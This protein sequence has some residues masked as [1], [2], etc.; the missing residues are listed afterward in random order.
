M[1]ASVDASGV[2]GTPR[3]LFDTRNWLDYDVA[4][5]G[6]FIAVVSQKVAGQEPLA[7]ILNWRG[8]GGREQ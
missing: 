3:V 4:R 7:V 8:P 5:D 2:T 1:A 6:R